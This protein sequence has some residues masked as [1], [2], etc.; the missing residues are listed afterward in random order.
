MLKISRYTLVAHMPRGGFKFFTCPKY[1]S[2]YE[3]I[4]IEGPDLK[5]IIAKNHVVRTV[6]GF[7]ARPRIVTSYHA[8]TAVTEGGRSV[9]VLAH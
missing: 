4:K 6:A 9:R 7:W 5:Q 3:V 2:L 8:A 1:K